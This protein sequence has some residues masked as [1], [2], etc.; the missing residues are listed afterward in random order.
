MGHM[1]T[2]WKATERGNPMMGLCYP[3]ALALGVSQDKCLLPYTAL[4]DTGH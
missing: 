3:P 2:H 4:D 1:T